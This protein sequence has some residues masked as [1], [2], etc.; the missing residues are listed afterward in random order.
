V[1]TTPE[2]SAVRDADRIIGLLQ[3]H[4][5]P[6]ELILNRLSTRM[7]EAG[8]MMSR[9]DVVDILSVSLI[10]VV[11]EDGEIVVA[12][13][14]GV[15]AVLNPDSAA[16]KAYERICRRILGEDVPIPSFEEKRGLLAKIFGR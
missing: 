11:P 10:G 8:E 9:E 6:I 4:G 16:G 1:V 14:Q 7:V 13:N 5:L 3:H 2:V 15:P 12:G